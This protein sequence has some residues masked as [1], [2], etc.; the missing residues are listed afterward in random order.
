MW[1]SLFS[2]PFKDEVN[3]DITVTVIAKAKFLL[4]TCFYHWNNR[5]VLISIWIDLEYTCK[6]T[7][8]GIF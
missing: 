1:L 6:I 8:R 5:Y 7:N 4:H 2:K 3:E